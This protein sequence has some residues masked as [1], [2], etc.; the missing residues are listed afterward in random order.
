MKLLKTRHSKAHLPSTP[1]QPKP[2]LPYQ[3][4]QRLFIALSVGLLVVLTPVMLNQ[5]GLLFFLHA[6]VT[7]TVPMVTAQGVIEDAETGQPLAHVTIKIRNFRFETQTETDNHGRFSIRVPAPAH[8]IISVPNYD[9]L[10]LI[11]GTSLI[12]KLAP[13]P[14]LTARRFMDTFMR[15]R[16]DQLWKMLAPDAQAFWFSRADF[17]HFLTRKFGPLP[18]VSYAVGQQAQIV[19]TWINPDTTLSYSHVAIVPVSL[20]IGPTTGVLSPSSEQ[21][22]I[23]GLFTHQ[24]I[25][26]VKCAGLWRILVAGPLDREA[27]VVVPAIPPAT[28]AKVPILMYHHI[29]A[30][31]TNNAMDYG[32]TVKT[33][34]F[35][36]QMAYLAA[37][38]YHPITLTDIFNDLYYGLPLPQHPIV[39]SFD[40]GYEDNF[41]DAFP[42]LQQHHFVAEINIIT[43]MI[44]GRYLTWD[45]IR[46]MAASGIEIGSH[47]IHHISLAEADPATAE[48]ELLDSKTT[49]EQQLG[50]PIQFFCYPSGEPF[51]HGSAARQQFITHLLYQDGYVGALLDPG[52]TGIIQNAQ[53]PYQLLRIRVSGGEQLSLFITILNGLGAGTGQSTGRN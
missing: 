2:S 5:L 50:Q 43:G 4:R 37:H 3:R 9:A 27:P 19:P 11:P 53:T 48:K 1:Q 33:P 39:M 17:T 24:K 8:I 38:G 44:G 6:P 14:I 21:E 42:I 7:S 12:V 20:K 16:F 30:R 41:T 40:D 49:L 36:A 29:S 13:T 10:P 34:D 32:L 31:P 26:E 35:A 51:H 47:T 28:T 15:Q 46:Q 23:N 25:A 52:A 22:V 18:L 45:Q